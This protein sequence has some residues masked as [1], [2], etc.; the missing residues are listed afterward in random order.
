MSFDTIITITCV[1]FLLMI[2]FKLFIQNRYYR[3]G[4]LG[5][6]K[7]PK[8]NKCSLVTYVDKF[9]PGLQVEYFYHFELDN[10]TSWDYVKSLNQSHRRSLLIQLFK[11]KL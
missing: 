1:I 8:G 2:F 7:D 9:K 10:R 5:T 3:T 11:I 6:A 4:W